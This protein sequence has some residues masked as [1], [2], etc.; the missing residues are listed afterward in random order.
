MHRRE[1]KLIVAATDLVGFLECGHLTNLDRAL[2]DG[3]LDKPKDDDDP[4][5]QL[6][7]WR[8]EEHEKRYIEML[9]ADHPVIADLKPS[10]EEK[11]PYA[12]LA[13]RTEEAMRRGDDVIY[14]GFVYDG[15]WIGYPDFLIKVP[16]DSALGDWHYEVADTKLARTAK[17]AALVQIATYVELIDRIQKRVPEKVRVVTGGVQPD[18]REFRTA[19]MMAYYRAAKARFES[20]LAT[21]LDLKSTYPD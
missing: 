9:R 20:E 12:Q 1:G 6:L 7:R 3:L 19:E 11:I 4:V 15:R 8:G 16:G 17:A 10:K 13:A 5:V 2:A 21:E 14:Q 18:V